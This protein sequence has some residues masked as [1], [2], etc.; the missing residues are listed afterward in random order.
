MDSTLAWLLESDPWVR[1]RA[2]LDLAGMTESDPEVAAA[3]REMLE[4][5]SVQGVLSEVACWPGRVLK[6]HRS[7]GHPIHRLEF[8]ADIGLRAGDPRIEEIIERVTEH[9][10]PDGP[11]QVLVNIPKHYGGTG[12]DSWGW[13]L[14][15]APSWSTLCS[16][17]AWG[18]ISGSRL[19]EHTY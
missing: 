19:P 3:R 10:S 12:E 8:L 2:L 18:P 9:R 17:S 7:A 13:A 11:F 5:P 4:H 15:D 1:Y 16:G 14:C 6:S